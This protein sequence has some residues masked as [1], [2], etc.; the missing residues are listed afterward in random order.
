MESMTV[1]TGK[2]EINM[3]VEAKERHTSIIAQ[4]CW[5]VME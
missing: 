2:V 1:S 4:V 5:M 3:I